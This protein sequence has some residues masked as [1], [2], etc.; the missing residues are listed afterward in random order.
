V[1]D[2]HGHPT[3][4]RVLAAVAEAVRNATR[5]GDV[6]A[7]YGGEEFAIIL[8]AT[9]PDS[10]RKVADRMRAAV[11]GQAIEVDGASI[12]VTISAGV[13]LNGDGDPPAVVLA[14]ADRALYDAKD[15]GRNRVCVSASAIAA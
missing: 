1:N 10:A 6:A 12:Q 3:G 15:G 11:A 14:Q 2:A 4:D 8:P 9:N 5:W 13:T 7:R